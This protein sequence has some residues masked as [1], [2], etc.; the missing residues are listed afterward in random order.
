MK[1]N[2]N[3]L[4]AV[5]IMASHE[6]ALYYLNG[7]CLVVAEN[8]FNLVATNGYALVVYGDADIRQ[9]FPDGQKAIIPREFI[10]KIKPHKHNPMGELSIEGTRVKIEHDG[11]I[12]TS[13]LIDETF[14]DIVQVIPIALKATECIGF[15][16][17]AL[18][19]FAKVAKLMG[20][21]NQRL[22]FDFTDGP[23]VIRPLGRY[24][25]YGVLAPVKQVKKGKIS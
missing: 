11:K 5:S 18:V 19:C 17:Q 10:D 4:K 16:G 8:G 6:K 15:C 13:E 1:I 22:K 14:P 3:H 24:N 7:V 20:D 21:K 9:T 12:M 2:L 23:A 25:W